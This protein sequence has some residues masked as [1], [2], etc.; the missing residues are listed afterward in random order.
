MI[1]STA[2]LLLVSALQTPAPPFE[3][4]LP[5]GYLA[6]EQADPTIQ[7]WVSRRGDDLGLF[8]VERFIITAPGANQDATAAEV[9]AF[10]QRR[11]A[12]VESSVQ[13]WT[14]DWLQRPAAGAEIRYT[15]VGKSI[16]VLERMLLI[17]TY[18][19]HALWEGPE[20][21]KPA[22]RQALHALTVPADWFPQPPPETDIYRGIGEHGVPDAFPGSLRLHVDL[23]GMDSQQVMVVDVIWD[24]PE[25][26][27]TEG[28]VLPPA[29]QEMKSA[30]P[31]PL[32]V[33][34]RLRIDDNAGA[35][36][37]YG[38]TRPA[39]GHGIA[40]LNANWVAVPNVL[41]EAKAGYQPPAWTLRIS[42]AANLHAFS[43]GEDQRAFDEEAGLL[44]S[45]YPLFAAGSAWPFFLVSAVEARK[46]A[47]V[48]WFLRKDAKATAPETPIR[49]LI[50]LD[51]IL[52]G[53]M[54]HAPERPHLTSYPGT[55]DRA[56]PGLLVLDENERWFEGPLD[57]TRDG[58]TRRVWLA[59][60]VAAGTFGAGLRGIGSGAPILEGAL[61][62]Y[63]A[64]RLLEKD[65][66]EDAAALRATWVE[67]EKQMGA[68]PMPLSMMPAQDA[69]GARRLQ[70]RGPL[71]WQAIERKA[72][73]A[74]L[75]AILDATLAAGQPWTTRDLKAALDE[76][77][78]ENWNHFFRDYVYGRLT[79][80]TDD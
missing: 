44:Q 67:R 57:A 73:R 70:S 37:P 50:R 34:Y 52:R 58:L 75:D 4:P 5:E 38:M 45:T 68:L 1:V 60:A 17:D 30:E 26:M 49:G 77:T 21:Q 3:L 63:A 51:E 66:A 55:G 25:G 6:F 18:L 32:A 71:V 61:S 62:E 64:W 76:A 16:G 22:A 8:K 7:S 11:L 9:T 43:F 65:W 39:I 23:S 69:F 24:A 29:A 2:A 56:M 72:G 19:I 35:G 14:G 20:G 31:G 13:P 74:K 41:L 36:S 79:P 10:W 12:D 80:P 47:G 33:R 53:W 28:W 78:G 46:E 27:T 15:K 59:R 42:Y 54:P 40:A 48:T